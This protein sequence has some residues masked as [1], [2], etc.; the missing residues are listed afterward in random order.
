VSYGLRLA[1]AAILIGD[2]WIS[3]PPERIVIEESLSEGGIAVQIYYVSGGR[4]WAR[5]VYALLL[6]V[7]TVNAIYYTSPGLPMLI[8]GISLV[9]EYMSMYWLFTEPGRRWFKR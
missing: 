1:S 5:L 7:R 8:M 9:C 6:G 4:N 2:R 3:W